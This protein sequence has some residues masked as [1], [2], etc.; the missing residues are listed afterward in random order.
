MEKNSVKRY[1]NHISTFTPQVHNADGLYLQYILLVASRKHVTII[2][3]VLL[4]LPTNKALGLTTSR[5]TPFLNY[6]EISTR[7]T[8]A[9][10]KTWK[11]RCLTIRVVF[12]LLFYHCHV[13]AWDG[14]LLEDKN[15]NFNG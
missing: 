5:D 15:T 11:Y 2:E 1:D 4:R 14:M 6:Y 13:E 10:E 8:F 12:V 3:P 9:H 7:V